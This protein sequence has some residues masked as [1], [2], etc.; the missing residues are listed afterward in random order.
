[1][2]L[3]WLLNAI[4]SVLILMVIIVKKNVSSL[5]TYKIIDIVDNLG[6]VLVM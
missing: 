2:L 4:D 6:I 3:L 5:Y 1:M